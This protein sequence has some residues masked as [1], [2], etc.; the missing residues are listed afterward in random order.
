MLGIWR[1]AAV[2]VAGL[3]TTSVLGR[4]G[5][6][7]VW[8]PA[9]ELVLVTSTA[10]LRGPVHGA[11]VGL[12]TGWFLTLLPPVGSPMGAEALTYAAAGAAAGMLADRTSRSWLRPLAALALAFIVLSLGTWV[13]AILAT[14]TFTPA[15]SVPCLLTTMAVGAITL[16]A[17][18]ALDR[19]LVRRRLG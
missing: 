13:V 10:V 19:A 7:S 18:L 14:G 2:I 16:P 9:L 17:V 11:W 8:M 1:A 4:Y 6:S 5:V 12:A 15:E 3:L